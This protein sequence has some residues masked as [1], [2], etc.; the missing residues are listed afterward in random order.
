MWHRP[1]SFLGDLR[2]LIIGC[3]WVNIQYL[4]F[5]GMPLAGCFYIEAFRWGAYANITDEHKLEC[6]RYEARL[7][8]W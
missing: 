7:E 2:M 4:W 3:R 8:A 5:R 6:H 1:L